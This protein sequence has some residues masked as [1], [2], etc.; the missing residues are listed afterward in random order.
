VFFNLCVGRAWRAQGRT[1]DAIRILATDPSHNW[2]YLAYAHERAGR[3]EE[4]EKLTAEAPMLYPDRRGAF[5]YALVFAGL[6]DQ[7]R[8]VEQLQRLAGVGPV[9]MG[10]TLNGPEFAFVRGDL[11]VKALRKQVGLPE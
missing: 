9:R 4:A 6:S 11:R 10:F 5:Q 3:R 8:T 2:G 7:D 1:N